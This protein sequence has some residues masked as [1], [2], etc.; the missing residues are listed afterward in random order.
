MA[1]NKVQI[2]QPSNKIYIVSKNGINPWHEVYGI[3]WK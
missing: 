1:A 2:L 3:R